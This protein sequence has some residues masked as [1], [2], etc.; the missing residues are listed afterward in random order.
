MKSVKSVDSLSSSAAY[1]LADVERFSRLVVGVPLRPYQVAPLRAV[2]DSI[3]H[4]RGREF[5]L[6]FPRPSGKN[7][8]VAQLLVYLLT[9][10]P[11]RGGQMVYGAVGDGLGRGMRRLE[12]RLDT[13]WTRGRWRRG[14][15]PRRGLPLAAFAQQRAQGV[16]QFLS[17][18]VLEIH[19]APPGGRRPASHRCR[20]DAP[21]RIVMPGSMRHDAGAAKLFSRARGTT[22]DVKATVRY[23]VPRRGAS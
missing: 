13:P 6:V 10:F 1:V 7:E 20:D 19:G 12:E 9:L 8:A 16:D 2:V 11:R 21:P 5:L 17:A 3:I 18:H 23:P 14:G 22:D 4:R 15:T